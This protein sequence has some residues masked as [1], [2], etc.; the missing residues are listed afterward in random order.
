M[1]KHNSSSLTRRKF[2]GHV[3]GATAAAMT[4]G[5]AASPTLALQSGT[6]AAEAAGGGRLSGDGRRAQQAY[7]VRHKAALYQRTRPFPDHRPNGDEERYANKIGSYS[8]ALPHDAVGDV[9][10]GA[11]DA[12]VRAMRTGSPADFAAVP[13]GGAVKLADPQAAL[14]FDLEGAD[15]HHLGTPAP[16]AFAS[17][18]EAGEMIELYWQ[19]LTRDVPFAHYERDPLVAAAVSDLSRF[20]NFAGVTAATLF[21]GDTPGDLAGP[22]ISQ[23]LWKDVPFGAQRLT[24]KYRVPTSG[25]DHMTAYQTWLDIQNGAPPTTGNNFDSTAR[26]IRHNRDLGEWDHRDFTYQGFLN[27]ALILLSFG[28][29]AL[30]AANPY[31]SSSNQSGFATFGGP[32]IL[33]A[34]ARVANCAL[35]ATWYQKWSVHRRA[36]PEEFGGRVHNH[37]TG[38][39]SYPI[40]A[41]LLNSPALTEV[42]NKFGTYLLPMAYPEGCPTHPAYPSGHAAIAGACVTVLKA[43]FDESFPISAPVE[44]SDDGLSLQPYTGATLTVG[45]ELNKLAANVALGR[46]AAGVHWRSDGIEGLKLGEAVALS[47]LED[48]KGC[49]NEEFEGFSLTKFDGTAVTI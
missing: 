41:E 18:E 26:Y 8:K 11:Y 39:A 1:S 4:A 9:D 22:Y 20:S 2:L 47:I 6:D 37:V 43:F 31:K 19:A 13:V 44:A 15:S 30:D 21:R 40:D 34:V 27:A 16:P 49:F 24:Q 36:R 5:F 45:G 23:F 29:A 10:G 25:D 3:G 32:H 48:M 12:L 7:L 17:E 14:A 28:G 38:A 35:K 42:S 33:D 46:D